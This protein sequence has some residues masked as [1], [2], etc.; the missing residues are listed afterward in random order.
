LLESG[1]I[2]TVASVFHYVFLGEV[3]PGCNIVPRRALLKD[4]VDIASTTLYPY[5]VEQ[6]YEQLPSP[7]DE[8]SLHTLFCLTRG[9]PDESYSTV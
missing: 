7:S 1:Y 3:Q 4:V 8:G 6:A 9:F 5:T 2:L